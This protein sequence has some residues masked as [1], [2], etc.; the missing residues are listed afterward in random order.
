M[1]RVVFVACEVNG[2]SRTQAARD[3]GWPEGTVAA[4]LAKARELLAARLT[5]RGVTLTAGLFAAVGVPAALAADTLGAVRELL[6][7]GVATSVVPT[8][9][10]LS[11]EVVKSMSG[12]KLKLLAVAALLVGLT[13]GTV[14]IASPGE[15]P[16]PRPERKARENAP[17]PKPAA[18]E[19]KEG[20]SIEFAD[21][22]R[23]TGVAFAPSG[24]T[25]AVCRDD[26]R[27]DFFDP[28]TRK[29]Q[30]RMVLKHDPKVNP[31]TEVGTVMALAFRPRSHKALGDVFA[32]THK[33]GV[34]FGTTTIGLLVDNAPVVDDLPQN[35]AANDADPHQAVWAGDGLV[36]TSGAET[37]HRDPNGKEQ[38]VRGWADRKH[39]PCA[40]AAMPE[41]GSWLMQ[42]DNDRKADDTTVWYWDAT[43]IK[44]CRRLEGHPSRPIAAAVSA[45]GKRIVT[46]DEGG[47]LIV[48]E[49][50]KFEEKRRI[51]QGPGLAA[52]ALAPDGKMV[53]VLRTA[54]LDKLGPGGTATWF[55]LY[56]FDITNPPAKPKPIWT[57]DKHLDG[58]FRGPASLAFSPDGKTLLAA[59]ADPYP[60]GNDAKSSGV[61]V[62]ELVPKK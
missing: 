5:K 43:D 35:W 3:L 49:G 7:V 6:A 38:G 55:G 59:F 60:T 37:H 22:G 61:R 41:G 10:T 16:G 53:A 30:Q 8:A 4:R 27:I 45:D 19:W 14:L 29:H 15:K 46:G 52:L 24:K 12:V 9:Q 47:T 50:E 17:V 42:F 20:K 54:G 40:L 28:A 33:N 57:T 32:V 13:A 56:V 25:F 23:V 44:L 31:N 62:W 34:N 2:R 21:G 1:Y 11:D 36:I 18:D 48:W 51:E 58:E 26:G 39:R